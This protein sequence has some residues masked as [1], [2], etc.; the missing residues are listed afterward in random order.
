MYHPMLFLR[1]LM[2]WPK[3]EYE[4]A[5]K[6]FDGNENKAIYERIISNP[7]HVYKLVKEMQKFASVVYFALVELSRQTGKYTYWAFDSAL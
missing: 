6:E 7:I 3:E 2:S 5:L 4:N 1:M